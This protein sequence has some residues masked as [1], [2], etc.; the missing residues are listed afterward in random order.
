[1]TRQRDTVL[2]ALADDDNFRSAQDLYAQ[3]RASSTPIGLATV[4]RAL[5]QL[6]DAAA[7][8]VLRTDSGEALYRRCGTRHHH[9]LICRS[10]GKTVEVAA[11]PVEK[12]AQAVARRHGFRQPQ[13][14]V[15]VFGVCRE[16]TS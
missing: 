13:H 11:E 9:H 15:E 1:M 3:L 8:D 4:Y 16:C 2:Q 10:C 14:R 5:Q 6:A 7:V 12:W